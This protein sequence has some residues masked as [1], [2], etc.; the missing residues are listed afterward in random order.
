MRTPVTTLDNISQDIIDQLLYEFNNNPSY[1]E[2]A[3]GRKFAFGM[4][5]ALE[6]L[7]PMINEYLDEEWVVTGGNY[8]STEAGYMVH[9]DTGRGESPAQVLQTF[10]FPLYIERNLE[11]DLTNPDNRL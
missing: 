7:G 5:T 1:A 6:L 8:F 3:Y 4:R 9:T 11:L 2:H 10:V